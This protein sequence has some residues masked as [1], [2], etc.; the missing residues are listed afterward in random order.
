MRRR[1]EGPG[2]ENEVEAPFSAPVTVP[3]WKRDL[4]I[5]V[6]DRE[7]DMQLSYYRQ[8]KNQEAEGDPW[9][10]TDFDAGESGEDLEWLQKVDTV[11]TGL[12][13]GKEH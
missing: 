13:S 11:R 4:S 9:E 5:M 12:M 1:D 8:S 10:D 3:R 7:K 2:R 6:A